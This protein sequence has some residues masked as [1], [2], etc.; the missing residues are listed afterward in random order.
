ML[1]SSLILIMETT[2]SHNGNWDFPHQHIDQYSCND[3]IRY[4][5]A[6]GDFFSIHIVYT[7]RNGVLA[8]SVAHAHVVTSESVAKL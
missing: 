4:Y 5:S 8:S 1:E 3:N 7:A 2:I 6:A